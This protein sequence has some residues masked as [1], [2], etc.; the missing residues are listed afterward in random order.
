[1]L[2]IVYFCFGYHSNKIQVVQEHRLTMKETK[3]NRKYS[4]LVYMV[5]KIGSIFFII[6]F[7]C[8]LFTW[9]KTDP[10]VQTV[11]FACVP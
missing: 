10:S 9:N 11:A 1:M 4:S 2:Q 8:G 3:A 7:Y 5:G 6:R